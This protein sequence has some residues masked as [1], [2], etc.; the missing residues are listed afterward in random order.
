MRKK[1]NDKKRDRYGQ[2]KKVIKQGK[3]VGAVKGKKEKERKYMG[4]R[5]S[6][7]HNP[8]HHSLTLV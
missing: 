6:I 3:W 5:H 1:D 8:S 4:F 2:Q 7:C